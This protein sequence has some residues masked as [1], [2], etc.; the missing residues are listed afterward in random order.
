[1]VEELTDDEQRVL[2][3]QYEEAHRQSQH[4]WDTSVRTI[5][6]AAVAVTASLVVL[7]TQVVNG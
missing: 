2:V 3:E 1:M 7:P 6:A 4:S 5:A